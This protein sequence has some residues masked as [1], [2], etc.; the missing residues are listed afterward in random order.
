MRLSD[1]VLPKP[2]SPMRYSLLVLLL[3]YIAAPHHAVG[4]GP[5]TFDVAY[6]DTLHVDEQT[7]F[8]MALRAGPIPPTG[9][10]AFHLTISYDASLI[11]FDSVSLAHPF[12]NT[13]LINSHEPTPGLIHA[14]VASNVPV[15]H[16]DTLLLFNFHSLDQRGTASLTCTSVTI[17]ESQPL[18]SC[19]PG[20]VIIQDSGASPSL[21]V[22]ETE[23]ESGEIFNVEVWL[24]SNYAIQSGNMTLRYPPDVL[25]FHSLNVEGTFL[26]HTA[27]LAEYVIDE[28]SG[29]LRI[30]FASVISG[31][32]GTHPLLRLAFTSNISAGEALLEILSASLND[33]PLFSLKDG[34]VRILPIIVPGDVDNDSKVTLEDVWMILRHVIGDLTFN[35]EALAAGDVSGNDRISSYDAS[36]VLHHVLGLIDCFPVELHCSV[37]KQYT[38]NRSGSIPESLFE[39]IH[40]PDA[41]RGHLVSSLHLTSYFPVEA[42]DVSIPLQ[43]HSSASNDVSVEDVPHGW[44]VAHKEQGQHLRI[45]MT[46]TSILPTGHVLTIRGPVDLARLADTP[47]HIDGSTGPHV[48]HGSVYPNN[49]PPVSID[50]PFPNPFMDQTTLLIKVSQTTRVE[51][52][53]YDVL[54]RQVEDL[55]EFSLATGTHSI[56]IKLPYAPAGTYF[57]RIK[58]RPGKTHIFAITKTQ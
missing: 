34:I 4:Q 55:G 9:I 18:A 51:G 40:S 2:I 44:L 37:Q 47:I 56:P 8:K 49:Q 3:L 48:Q 39:W 30:A 21:I 26:D 32:A 16:A 42:L 29:M 58:T 12:S 54:G 57:A 20:V 27:A 7:A 31:L 24:S 5:G 19:A 38:Q 45:S 10:Q 28:R 25:S 6:F 13:S 36:L 1:R 14:A 17:N 11:A 15:L 23:A 52:R 53:I 41:E 43:S 50:A 22:E 46:G 33:S 35:D